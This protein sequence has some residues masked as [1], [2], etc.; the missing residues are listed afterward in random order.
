MRK[1]QRNFSTV[2]EIEQALE[3]GSISSALKIVSIYSTMDDKG[4]K[5]LKNTLALPEDF[6]WQIYFLKTTILNLI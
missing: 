1:N 3:N 4:K 2:E 6:C 5:L